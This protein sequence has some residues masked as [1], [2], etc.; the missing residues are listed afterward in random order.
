ML[1]LGGQ[2]SK[3]LDRGSVEIL[4]PFGLEKILLNLSKNLTNLDY[5]IITS[6]ALYLLLGLIF[7]MLLPYLTIYDNNLL[8]LLL[9]ILFFT[10]K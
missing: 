10:Q 2:T 4:G 1:K 7:Y 3:L 8:L 6:Y 5:G 9:L